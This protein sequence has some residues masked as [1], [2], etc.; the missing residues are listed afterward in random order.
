MESVK[1]KDVSGCK[2]Q[3]IQI[4]LRITES[5]NRNCSYCHWNKGDHYKTESILEILEFI[6]QEFKSESI[7]I[8]LHGGEPTLHPDFSLILKKIKE[9]NFELEVQTNFDKPNEI[10]K[11]YKYI[12]ILDLSF[13]YPINKNFKKNLLKINK[14]L[15]INCVDLVYLPKIEKEI[16]N[17]KKFLNSKNIHNEITYNYFEAA[18]YENNLSDELKSLIA[19]QEKTKNNY[20]AKKIK[21]KDNCDTTKYVIINGDGEVFRCSHQLTNYPSSGNILQNP[22]VLKKIMV[23]DLCPYDYCG[24][25]YEYLTKK[26]KN[27]I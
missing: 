2:N 4:T 12:D 26:A 17:M 22:K 23:Y 6:S 16:I 3:E 10:L 14:F 19:D 15:K 20:F 11:N 13:H 25:E 27:D 5:C 24:Y 18:Q 7:L 1:N 21:I 9:Y 8:Y